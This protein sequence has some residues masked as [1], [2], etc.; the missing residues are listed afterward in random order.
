[1][2]TLKKYC[3]LFPVVPVPVPCTTFLN[4]CP[5]LGQEI[6]VQFKSSDVFVIWMGM[7]VSSTGNFDLIVTLNFCNSKSIFCRWGSTLARFFVAIISNGLWLLSAVKLLPSRYIL[8]WW[9][10]KTIVSS[11]LCWH[12]WSP[13]PCGSC[14]WRQW[15]GLFHC[16]SVWDMLQGLW[17]RDLLALSLVMFSHSM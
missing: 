6:L 9:Q 16:A 2:I 12:T 13:H 4:T 17:G 14:L 7:L 5:M 15:V 3:P 8:M 1:M 11:S 10:A